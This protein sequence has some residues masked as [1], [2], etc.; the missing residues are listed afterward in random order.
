M[1]LPRTTYSVILLGALVWCAAILLPAFLANT[2]SSW[3]NEFVYR[4][5]HPICHQLPERSFHLFG[6][7]LAVCSRCSS[8]YFAFLIG[9]IGY[10]FITPSLHHIRTPL[11][12]V[13]VAALLPMLVDVALDFFGIHASTFATRTMSGSLFGLVVPFFVLPAA[14]EGVQQLVPHNPITI[15]QH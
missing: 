5:F 9:V 12:S 14:I 2:S 15:V 11:R 4:S 1:N 7:R 6:E 3:L 13:L 8:I 10:P